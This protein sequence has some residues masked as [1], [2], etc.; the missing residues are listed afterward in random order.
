MESGPYSAHPPAEPESFEGRCWVCGEHGRFVREHLAVGRTFHCPA[1]RSILRYQAQARALVHHLSRR[2]AACFAELVKE[3]RFRSLRI[4]E[5]GELGPF[6]RY[7]RRLPGYEVSIYSPG[8]P[9][10]EVRDAVRNEDLMALTYRSCSFDLVIT[11]DVFEHVRR[12]YEGFAEIHRVLRP[13]GAHVFT[14]PV[15]W[16]MRARTTERVDT[17]GVENVHLLEPRYH[18]G[19][20]VYNDFGRDML[21]RLD[22]I[23]F[24]TE[25]VR[26]P[27]TNAAAAR[28]LSF[29]S[30][31]RPEKE[32][33]VRRSAVVT[34]LGQ[35][36]RSASA[37]VRTRVGAP[38][39]RGPRSPS[40]PRGRGR[41]R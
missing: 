5:P 27:S 12:P 21:D 4:Y 3:R 38:P 9:R 17:T 14:V 37:P 11:S 33:R 20:L 26:F 35:V 24:D 22:E 34:R 39:T 6:R 19:H 30:V 15:R 28:V 40:V 2:D 18:R 7:L 16:P 29:C 31:K 8:A 10:G 13:G 32:L 36:L 25:V 1:C 23:G 41:S